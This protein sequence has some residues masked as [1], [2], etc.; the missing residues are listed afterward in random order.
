MGAVKVGTRISTYR[1][2]RKR[3]EARTALKVGLLLLVAWICLTTFEKKCAQRSEARH[4]P[5]QPN[6]S[7][8]AAYSSPIEF[9]PNRAPYTKSAFVIASAFAQQQYSDEPQALD[10]WLADGTTPFNGLLYVRASS[11]SPNSSSSN[12]PA[13][14]TT[15]GGEGGVYRVPS[16]GWTMA[17]A[18]RYRAGNEIANGVCSQ[19]GLGRSPASTIVASHPIMNSYP[20][21]SRPIPAGPIDVNCANE[22][23]RNGPTSSF[24]RY[25]PRLSLSAVPFALHLWAAA[26]APS[27]P[28]KPLAAPIRTK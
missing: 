9:A 11:Q 4:S 22:S 25:E 23:A 12:S 3:C 27:H 15:S 18:A 17:I 21:Y 1:K 26:E 13:A 28:K 6:F 10:V 7:I 19:L 24:T 20:V 14:T 2:Y 16:E 5:S 8:A